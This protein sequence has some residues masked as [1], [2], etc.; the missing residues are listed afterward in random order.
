MLLDPRFKPGVAERFLKLI[1]NVNAWFVFA[2]VTFLKKRW[3]DW[4][5]THR[6][7]QQV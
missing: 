2:K 1:G 3:F 4:Q 6:Y 5:E 7:T